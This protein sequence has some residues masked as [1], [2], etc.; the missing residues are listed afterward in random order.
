MAIRQIIKHPDQRLYTTCTP[1][2]FER[3]KEHMMDLLHTFRDAQGGR[4]LGLS[5]PQIGITLCA[6]VMRLK[7][8]DQGVERNLETVVCNPVITHRSKEVF[9]MQEGCLSLPWMKINVERPQGVKGVFQNGVG[10]MVPFELSGMQARIF[11]H[12]FEH[13]IGCTLSNHKHRS[14]HLIAES[15]SADDYQ[16]PN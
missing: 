7:Y 16:R 8:D 9:V 1:I 11:Q 13:L 15:V 3:D 4:A 6:F 12:E 2:N 10:Q 5:M 14:A